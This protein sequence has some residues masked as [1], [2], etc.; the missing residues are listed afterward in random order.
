MAASGDP[1]VP[2]GCS[3]ERTS[4]SLASARTYLVIVPVKSET[5]RLRQQELH[6]WSSS[7]IYN[8]LYRVYHRAEEVA[9]RFGPKAARMSEITRNRTV[10][11]I[12]FR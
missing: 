12:A 11:D 5:P 10:A 6:S 3:A 4:L 8:Q 7:A 2:P 1:I 9:V